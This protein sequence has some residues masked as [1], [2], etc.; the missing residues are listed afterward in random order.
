[1]FP[2]IASSETNIK[3]PFSF[4]IYGLLAFVISQI[5]LLFSGNYLAEGVFRV[6]TVWSAVHL[7][8]LGWALM[9]AMGAM[10]Q[11]VPVVFLT[12]IWNETFGFIQFG[13]YAVGVTGF[14][15]SLFHAPAY[16]IYTGS[17]ALL[18]IIMFIFQMFM[19]IKNHKEKNIITALVGTALT[20]LLITITLGILLV[21]SLEFGIDVNHLKLLKSHIVFGVTGWFTLL[22]FAFSYKLAPMFS[23]SHG[24]SMKLS[25]PIYFT[26]ICGLLL[27]IISIIY[28]VRV[29]FQLGIFALFVAFGIFGYHVYT[30]Y[31]KRLK[32]K[33][34]KPFAFSL[35]A[36]IFGVVIHFLAAIL[37]FFPN[38]YE[39]FGIII[40]LYLFMWIV[41]SILGYLYK[42]VPFLWWTYKYSEKMGK[43]NVPTLKQMMNEKI[44]IPVFATLAVCVVGVALSIITQIVIL[45]YICQFI[46]VIASIIYS[47][48]VINVL[49]K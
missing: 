30:I 33:L 2:S 27:I 25:K 39:L 12:R 48:N 44:T 19:T 41:F 24:Y 3:L 40:Y 28:D 32:K 47:A 13:V 6:P 36:I 11:L 35:I 22:I 31:L 7:L 10:Y 26:Y 20:C 42:I 29:L 34:D 9:V 16:M 15:I 8:V 43:Q 1:M 18:G 38:H 5:L 45:F 37:S 49:R 14:A 4:I 46:I 17:L 23:L 21:S